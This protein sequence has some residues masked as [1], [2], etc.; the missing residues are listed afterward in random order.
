MMMDFP[1]RARENFDEPLLNQTPQFIDEE[2]EV[3]DLCQIL[4]NKL[5][6]KVSEIHKR[7]LN[8]YFRLM[9]I[10]LK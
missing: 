4:K 6:E 1:I 9:I 5:S 7:P 8:M 10:W 3:K 2:T